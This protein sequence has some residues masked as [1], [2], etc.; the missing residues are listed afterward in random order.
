MDDT[1]DADAP[2]AI[3][4][5]G[6]GGLTVARAIR[7]RLPGERVVY[8]GDTA[9]V[10]YGC[11]GAETVVGFARQIVGYLEP[12]RPKHVVVACNTA[13]AVAL[14]AIKAAFPHLSVSGVVDPGARAACDAAGAKRVPVIGVLAT[15]ATVRS[16]AYERAVC[17]RRHYAQVVA[18]AAPLLVPIIEDGRGPDDPIAK[19]AVAEYV[20][21]IVDRRADVL[22]LGCTHYPVLADLIRAAVGPGCDVIDSAG[23]CAEDVARR[24]AA[25]GRLRPRL[26]G[27][28]AVDCFVTD[29]ARRFQRHARRLLG[30]DLPE[31]TVVPVDALPDEPSSADLRGRGS[32]APRVAPRL[33][34]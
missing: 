25:A 3:L 24:L 4:D 1:R 10:P 33:A 15:E 2:I 18:V 21:P 30:I 26:G 16:K 7:D 13:T 14:P 22:I 31:P 6:I 34:G 32:V 29:D 17:R 27:G 12:M 8:F 11:K 20:R 19:L 5:S 9:R 23:R 28:G